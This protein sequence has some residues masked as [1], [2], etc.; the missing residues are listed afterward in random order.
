MTGEGEDHLAFIQAAIQAKPLETELRWSLFVSSLYSY[1]YDTVLKPFPP[2]FMKDNGEK[3]FKRLEGCVEDV[4]TMRTFLNP[5]KCNSLPKEVVELVRWV[6]DYRNFHLQLKDN[7]QFTEIK[8]MTKD[9]GVSSVDPNYIFE[10]EYD[11]VSSSKFEE[12]RNNRDLLYGYHGSRIENFYSILH[13]GLASHMN[14]V[15]VF[16]EGTY[17]SSELSVSLHYSPQGR[18]W[19]RSTLGERLGCIAVC[20]MIDDPKAVKCKVK[21]GNRNERSR[22]INSE[23]GDVPEKYYIVQNNDVI[24]VKYLLVYAQKSSN[25]SPSRSRMR[26]WVS[27]HKFLL[28]MVIYVLI[29]LIVGLANSKT[30]WHYVRRLTSSK[31]R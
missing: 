22:A 16:G 14:K 10:V 1:R 18:G 11:E 12:L 3:D 24:R 4:P 17:L 8:Q 26:A 7:N 5:A 9:S 29:L 15:S 2:M 19:E 25:V 20:E 21:D 27:K 23:A 30:F 28:M 13:H 31:L 6:L